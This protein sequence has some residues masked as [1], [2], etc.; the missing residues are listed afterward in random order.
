MR[1]PKCA[2]SSQALLPDGLLLLTQGQK[3]SRCVN[4]H[5]QGSYSIPHG[6]LG[7]LH[8]FS[9]AVSWISWGGTLPNTYSDVTCQTVEGARDRTQEIAIVLVLWPP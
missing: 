7:P 3:A 8:P 5:T 4:K 2:L 6:A 1:L 9:Y